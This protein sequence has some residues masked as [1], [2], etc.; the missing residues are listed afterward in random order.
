LNGCTKQV[1][2]QSKKP[3]LQMNSFHDKINTYLQTE[4]D[5][6]FKYNGI[7]GGITKTD[8]KLQTEILADQGKD[9]NKV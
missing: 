3:E 9:G 6:T 5:A 1:E 4:L 7:G 8:N 2:N